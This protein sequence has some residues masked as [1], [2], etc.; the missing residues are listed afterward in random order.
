MT[1]PVQEF[2]QAAADHG[3]DLPG[4]IIADGVLHR[5]APNGDKAKSNNGWYVLHLDTPA[6]GSFGCW[7][8]QISQTWCNKGITELTEAE[9]SAYKT[10]MDAMR[11]QREEEKERVQTECRTWCVDAWAKAKDATNDNPYLKLKGVHAYGLKSF[12]D[13]LL[14]LVRDLAGTIHGMQFIRP[15][16]TKKFKTGTNKTE[17]F[18]KIGNS[19]DNTIIICEGYAT[20]ASIHQATGHAVVVAFDCGNL[21]PVAT[22]IRAKFPD[23][24]IIVAADNDQATEGNPGLRMATEAVEVVG[25]LLAVPEFDMEAAL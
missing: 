11:Q 7:K 13:T 20:G 23:M 9:R 17:H 6:A 1:D 8:R 10:K 16:T 18:F 15:D 3:L 14:I 12:K 19:K 25:G 2:R 22:A 5:F 21:L 24:K 4:E